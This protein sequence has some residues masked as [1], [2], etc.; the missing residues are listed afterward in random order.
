MKN[1]GKSLLVHNDT[2]N[3]QTTAIVVEEKDILKKTKEFLKKISKNYSPMGI[4]LSAEGQTKGYA[5]AYEKENF[6][7]VSKKG[8]AKSARLYGNWNEA[9]NFARRIIAKRQAANNNSRIV[10]AE[11]PFEN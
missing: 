7:I 5:V 9:L 4:V 1:Q 3:N 11:Y 6:I 8:N 10:L 2:Q